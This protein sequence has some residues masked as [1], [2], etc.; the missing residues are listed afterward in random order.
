MEATEVRVSSYGRSQTVFWSRIYLCVVDELPRP[1]RGSGEE[2]SCFCSRAVILNG[3]VTKRFCSP[4]VR[5][6]CPHRWFIYPGLHL[7]GSLRPAASKI[8]LSLMDAAA[9]WELSCRYFYAVY[10]E[11]VHHVCWGCYSVHMNGSCMCLYPIN[12][13]F[14]VIMLLY[15]EKSLKEHPRIVPSSLKYSAKKYNLLKTNK[16]R[17]KW[18]NTFTICR[19]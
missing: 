2:I 1:Q 8:A 9:T 17:W 15:F 12:V 10:E 19:L 7:P 5:R 11:A 18:S 14:Y 16:K 4:W 13:Q 6:R 3:P